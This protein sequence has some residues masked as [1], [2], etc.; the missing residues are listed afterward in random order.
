MIQVLSFSSRLY[1]CLH[2]LIYTPKK[3]TSRH[4]LFLFFVIFLFFWGEQ[5]IVS[6][7]GWNLDDRNFPVMACLFARFTALAGRSLLQP[8]KAWCKVWIKESVSAKQEEGWCNTWGVCFLGEELIEK[9]HACHPALNRPLEK[10]L[11]KLFV[12]FAGK[13]TL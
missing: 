12:S 13:V 7:V 9:L 6:L 11:F 4:N 3:N 5:I 1:W 8:L 10:E 2:L